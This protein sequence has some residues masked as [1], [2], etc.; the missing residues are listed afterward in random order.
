MIT[1][2]FSYLMTGFAQTTGSGG[3]TGF[4]DTPVSVG[5]EKYNGANFGDFSIEKSGAFTCS[6]PSSSNRHRPWLA[7]FPYAKEASTTSLSRRRSAPMRF[8]IVLLALL[9]VGVVIQRHRNHCYWHGLKQGS[10][11]VE[12]LIRI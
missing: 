4:G 6:G 11:W 9:A 1:L 12:C 7:G 5:A 8:V 2:D 3:E 10:A